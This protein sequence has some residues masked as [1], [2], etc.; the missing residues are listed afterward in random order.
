MQDRAS[1]Q[2]VKWQ[3]IEEDQNINAEIEEETEELRGLQKNSKVK[4]RR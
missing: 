2:K 3:Q 1:Q 4:K